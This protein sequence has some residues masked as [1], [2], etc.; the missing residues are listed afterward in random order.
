MKKF[1]FSGVGGASRLFSKKPIALM[2]AATVTATPVNAETDKASDGLTLEEV[3]VTAQRREESIQEVPLS[4]TAFS[5]GTLQKLNVSEAKDFLSIA[6][7]VSF[8]EDGQV[9][10]RGV[11]ISIRGVSSIALDAGANPSSIGYYVDDLNMGVTSNGNV[12]PQLQ[13]ME[14]IEVLRGPQGTY[15]GRNALGGAINVTTKKPNENFY[16]EGTLKAESFSTHGAQVIANLPA[17]DTLMFRVV[18]DY[19]ES[20]TAVEN[21]NPNGND[22]DTE[23]SYLRTAVRWLPTD[24]VTLD[25]S[26]SHTDED[27]GGDIAVGTGAMDLDTQSIFSVGPFTDGVGFYPGNDSKVNNDTK[28]ENTNEVTIYNFRAN[29]D[30]D[31]WALTSIT[32][33]VDSE[34]TRVFDQDNVSSNLIERF[35]TG[36]ATAF[37][38]EVRFQST[39]DNFIDWTVGAYYADDEINNTNLIALG[40]DVAYVDPVTGASTGPILPPVGAGF[41]IN[42]NEQTYEAESLAFFGEAVFHL[43]EEWSLTVGGRYTR[44][45]IK[46]QAVNQLGFGSPVPDQFGDVDFTN[47]SPKFSLRFIPNEDLTV[48]FTASEGYKAG[49]VNTG[50]GASPQVPFDNEELTSLELGFKSKLADGRIQLSGAIYDLTWDDLQVQT[51]RLTVPGDISS[52]EEKTLNAAKASSRGVELEMLALLTEGLTW[53]VNFG[54]ID[55]KYDDFDLVAL[56][57]GNTAN[58]SGLDLPKTPELTASTYIDYSTELTNGLEGFV[59]FDMNYRSEAKGNV[60]SVAAA[61]LNLPD[62]PYVIGSYTVANLRFGVSSDNWRVNAYIENLFD[63]EY[64]TGNNDNF[65]L[66]GIRVRPHPRVVGASFTYMFGES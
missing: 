48:Y 27:E 55:A 47:F 25:F 29:I 19:E 23:Y 39:G 5:A 57:G 66:G 30:F 46:S 60:E 42:Y 38:Q 65:G 17:S 40:T 13:D 31:G 15:F 6:P 28:E 7:N 56:P 58:L 18:A 9:G 59:R 2:V 36:D 44:D 43:S 41:P 14:R 22:N 45:E 54:Y 33:Y 10:S 11:G 64:Y 16:V 4:V 34:N 37:S 21:I 51:N 50:F 35:N 20:E 24:D 3:V 26:I 32:G 49:G 1:L 12:N 8:S 62:Y 63:R 61:Q 52:A 53:S